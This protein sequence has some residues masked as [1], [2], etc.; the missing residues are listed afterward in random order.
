MEPT[1]SVSDSAGSTEDQEPTPAGPRSPVGYLR[2]VASA[3]LV[4]VAVL[5]ACAAVLSYWVDTVLLDTDTFV[6][7][8][9]PIV[10]DDAVRDEASDTITAAVIDVVDVRGLADAALAGAESSLADEI[11][12]GF[13]TFV[14]ETVS[15]AVNT[16]TF[17]D[18]WLTEMR[19]WHVKL[20]GAVKA[21][22]AEYAPDGTVVRVT[23]GPYI[24]L[25]AEQAENSFAQRLIMALV[26]DTVRTMQ[27]VVLDTEL[28]EN[29]LPLLRSLETARP[30]LPWIAASAL[31]LALIAAQKT[32]CAVLGTGAALSAGGGVAWTMARA[33]AARVA[34][35]MQST[36]SAS[37]ESATT[38]AETLFGPLETW[39]GYLA[40]AGILVAALGA[41]AA[42][43]RR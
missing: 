36:F 13:E 39:L 29:R 10:D 3:L 15:S 37:H 33:E 2:A 19:V 32:S 34:T 11:V 22:D 24:D 18:L 1:P 42:F 41:V 4:T 17:E 6:A 5:A 30:Y 43:R 20:V 23:L 25:L 14:G 12:A 40:L 16:D 9:E 21:S 28:V 38:F 8:V 7:A 35:L 31:L 27:V 26:P